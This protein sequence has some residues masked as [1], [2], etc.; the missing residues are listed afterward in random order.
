MVIVS[1]LGEIFSRKKLRHRDDI[2]DEILTY[3]WTFFAIESRKMVLEHLLH[4]GFTSGTEIIY[5][6]ISYPHP[7]L[8]RFIRLSQ[9]SPPVCKLA[10]LSV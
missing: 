8:I 7:A 9:I 2:F 5:R 6:Y 10:S 4:V 1:K 3:V